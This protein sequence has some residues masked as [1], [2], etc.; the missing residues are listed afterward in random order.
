MEA[1]FD[2]LG[3]GNAIVDILAYTDDDFINQ[4]QLNKGTMTLIDEKRAE[5]LYRAM[6][7][8]TE[9]SGGSV[10]NTI[11]GLASLGANTAF[12]GKVKND[13]FGTIFY[14]D[15]KGQNV[16]FTTPPATSG[17]PTAQCLVFVTRNE[18][19]GRVKTAERTM[20]TFLGATT[21]WEPG[22][23]DMDLVAQSKVMYVEGYLWDNPEAKK[24][25]LEA[26]KVAHENKRKVAFSL[27]DPLCVIRHREEFL[28]LLNGKVD[29]LF[30]NEKEV[31]ALFGLT[32]IRKILFKLGEMCEAAAVTRSEK[33]SFIVTR[34]G[35]I[36]SIDPVLVDEVYDVTGAGDLYA[37]GVLYGYTH[38]L[39]WNKA[40]KLGSQCAAE[41]IK[42]LGAR[43]LVKL[44]SLLK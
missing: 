38:G 7:A 1:K 2:V 33:G 37:A 20:A 21:Q 28:E 34:N 25:V 22:D 10:A 39:D 17:K 30:A 43:P 9:C 35:E 27:S 26:I 31:R 29:I 5:T 8:A 15:M 19:E 24:A 40:G 12:I 18:N 11:T 4:Y 3:V 14:R 16:H 13:P 6:G 36:H 44:A 41:V 32:D 23:M 42:Y